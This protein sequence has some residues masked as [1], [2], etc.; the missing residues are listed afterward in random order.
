ME[1]IRLEDLQNNKDWEKA[2]IVFT[3]DTW[4]K[5]FSEESRSYEV[6]RDNNYFNSDKISTSLYGNCL[7]GRDN[8]V[9]LDLYMSSHAEWKVDYCYIVQ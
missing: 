7:D 6:V 2:V 9:R 4:S 1:K 8:G 3:E 5:V